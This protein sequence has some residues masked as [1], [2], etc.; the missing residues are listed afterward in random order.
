[1]TYAAALSALGIDLLGRNSGEI[2]TRCPQCSATRSKPRD[3]CLSVNI[4][5]GLY[6]CHNCGWDGKAREVRDGYGVP[7]KRAYTRPTFTPDPEPADRAVAY[8]AKRGIPAGIVRAA[9]VSYRPVVNFPQSDKPLPAICFPYVR[10]GEVINVKYRGT[11]KTFRMEAGAEKCLYGLDG[12]GA[13]AVG[14]DPATPLVWC[15]G[16]IDALSVAATGYPLAVSVPNGALPRRKDGTAPNYANQLDYLAASWA[17]LDRHQRHVIATDGDDPGRLLGA[18]LIRRLGPERCWIVGWPE[19]TKDANDVLARDGIAG[20]R[21]ILDSAAP[22]PLDD[23]IGVDDLWSDMLHERDHGIERGAHPGS[24]ALERCYRI[25]PGGWTLVTGIPGH[26]KSTWLDWL[27]VNLARDHDWRIAIFSP[28][29]QPTFRHANNLIRCYLGKPI[30]GG[31]TKPATD[32]EYVAG[33]SWLREH[34]QFIAPQSETASIA[35]V[36]DIAAMLVARDG[37]RGV[38]IDPWSMLDQDRKPGEREDEYIRRAIA[39]LRRFARNA[40]VHVWVVAHPRTMAPP[41]DGGDYAVPRPYDVSG[42]S[43]FANHADIAISVY[44]PAKDQQIIPG[45]LGRVEIH[46]QKVKWQGIDG[47]IGVVTLWYDRQTGRYHDANE[48]GG[49]RGITEEY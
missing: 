21:A 9:G 12:F 18:E 46:V 42:G 1:M 36:T 38:V 20:L 45:E 19:G 49:S 22:A 33:A 3:P 44:R 24:V 39:K 14:D 23:V 13:G 32:D 15:E 27:I 40:G 43:Q 30:A 34:V 17:A 37:I 16:E 31:K 5:D 47:E 8:L 29:N 6:N 11:G 48:K 10:D 26:G 2:K 4:T 35:T 41:R 25:K 28:E 7:P